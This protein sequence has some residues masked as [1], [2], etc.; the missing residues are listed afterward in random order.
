M[1]Y[2]AGTVR[3]VNGDL[4]DCQYVYAFYFDEYAASS[5]RLL[6]GATTYAA[7]GGGPSEPHYANVSL[8]LRGGSTAHGST[9]ISD[10]GPDARLVSNVGVTVNRQ[11]FTCASSSSLEFGV[12]SYL[13]CTS[14]AD[15]EFGTG[16]FTIEGKLLLKS[17][18]LPLGE[19]AV[20]FDTREAAGDAGVVVWMETYDDGMG[21]AFTRLC[22]GED[23]SSTSVKLT[24]SS[25]SN[26]GWAQFSVSR[27]AGVVSLE[28]RGYPAVTVSDNS[29]KTGQN[30]FIG[31]DFAGVNTTAF[32]LFLD[33]FRVTKGVARPPLP[34]YGVSTNLAP[35][36]NALGH[37]RIDLGDDFED[38]HLVRVVVLSSDIYQFNDMIHITS[39]VA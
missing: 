13:S 12:G 11:M 2:V 6:G 29:N 21:G 18:M 1:S 35:N 32:T 10:V 26:Y 36:S 23:G 14:D 5:V 8:L 16:D 3:D 38:G 24:G 25:V 37:F 17:E 27:S 34:G 4:M 9:A 28:Q 15:F 7:E 39:S 20:I 19:K 31:R 22:Y 33:D 30:C